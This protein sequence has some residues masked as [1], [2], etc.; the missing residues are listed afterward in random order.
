MA[1][2]SGL[3]VMYSESCQKMLNEKRSIYLFA[4]KRCF[5]MNKKCT[6]PSC[7]K[8]FSTL[9]TNR[10]CPHCGKKYPQLS[11]NAN[12][13]ILK[14]FCIINC[15]GTNRVRLIKF[16]REFYN[17]SLKE[18]KYGVDHI[19]NTVYYVSEAEAELFKRSLEKLGHAY[20][21]S[22][23][24]SAHVKKYLFEADNLKGISVEGK[25]IDSWFKQPR[26]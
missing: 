26:V 2:K 4:K 22:T 23:V 6:N 12:Q 19:S 16:L 9:V 14:A 17:L 24:L 25:S 13:K 1:E 8:T 3:F 18:A 5:G 20:E 10:V 7:R 11:L 15:N 21:T